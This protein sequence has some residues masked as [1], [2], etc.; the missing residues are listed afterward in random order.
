MA[1]TSSK[2]S[3][4]SNKLLSLAKQFFNSTTI[5]TIVC[6]LAFDW[7]LV[8]FRPLRYL[9]A[10]GFTPLDQNPVFAKIPE[11]MKSRENPD[12]LVLGSSLVL[13]PAVR[14]DDA[15]EGRKTRYDAWYGRNHLAEYTKSSY[16]QNLLEHATGNHYKLT[17]LGVIASVMSDHSLIFEKTLASGKEPKLVICAL[18]PRD[19]MDNYRSQIDKTPVYQ[20]LADVTS[21]GDL[22][23]R[24]MPIAQVRDFLIGN[25]WYFYK[26]KVDYRTV[27]TL[28]TAKLSGHPVT[29][30][31]ATQNKKVPTTAKSAGGLCAPE[32]EA[33][34]E[35]GVLETKIK[36]DY[37][38]KPNTL[39]DLEQYQHVY[40]PPNR[41]LFKQQTGYLEK[42]L[43][44]ANRNKINLVLVNMPLSDENK[45]L[46]TPGFYDQYL[47]TVASTAN[48]YDIPFY[49]LDVRQNY[50]L[51]DFEDSC[52]MNYSGG[53]KF[54]NALVQAI[55]TNKQTVAKLTGQKEYIG[56][57][58][59]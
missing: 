20:V 55:T 23:D 17:N 15:F 35:V 27:A 52:H 12:V 42:M 18:A 58:S 43:K 11:F 38:P 34:Q 36:P 31:N 2:I 25:L 39:S 22:I 54:Y 8:S 1:E 24:G 9:N 50:T 40:N 51:S 57:N 44:L 48:K 3:G 30:F 53:Q 49:N 41:T 13:V 19:F 29:L 59:K 47:N 16:F 37:T 45:A 6:L 10:T 14:C 26:V 7:F 33:Q 21:L 28:A 46:I 56:S 4:T 32:E 5:L